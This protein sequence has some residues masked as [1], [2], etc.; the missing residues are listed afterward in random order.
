MLRYS[1]NTRASSNPLAV[2]RYIRDIVPSNVDIHEKEFGYSLPTFRAFSK[3]LR[4][5]RGDTGR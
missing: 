5:E 1:D 2:G 4:A 3:E